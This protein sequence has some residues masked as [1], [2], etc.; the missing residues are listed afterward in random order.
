MFEV[1]LIVRG[2][3]TLVVKNSNDGYRSSFPKHFNNINK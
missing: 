1:Y 2:D 3:Y